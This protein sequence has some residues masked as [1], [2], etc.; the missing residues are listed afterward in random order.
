MK[1]KSNSPEIKAYLHCKLCM[2][3]IPDTTCPA[4]WARLNV[5]WT[6]KGLQVWCERHNE[7]V[8]NLDFL[9]QQVATT[10]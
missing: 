5:G 4:D 8:I 10:R 1:T 6:K 2:G 3:E 7:N 9:G